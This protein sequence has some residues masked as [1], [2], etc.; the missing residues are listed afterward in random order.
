MDKILKAG[1]KEDHWNKKAQR[2]ECQEGSRSLI[3]E[4][5]T[6]GSLDFT[7]RALGR[8]RRY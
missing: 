3:M 5:L 4:G 7:L 2:N 8:Q 1:K 6:S